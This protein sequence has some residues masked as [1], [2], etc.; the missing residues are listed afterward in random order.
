MIY[1]VCVFVFVYENHRHSISLIA[2]SFEWR[3]L[4]KAVYFKHVRIIIEHCKRSVKHTTLKKYN[5]FKEMRMKNIRLGFFLLR[6]FCF[7]QHEPHWLLS[8]TA[9]L[10]TLVLECSWFES[11]LTRLRNTVFLAVCPCKWDLMSINWLQPASVKT[12]PIRLITFHLI[13]WCIRYVNQ[14]GVCSNARINHHWKIRAR[15][16]RT[17]I[18]KYSFVNRSVT[19]WNQL[20][21]GAIELPTLKLIFS[22]RGLGKCKMVEEVKTIKSKK[23]REVKWREASY[24][25]E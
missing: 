7:Q 21:E 12:S 11:G 18:G 5:D 16:Q 6:L 1:K 17:D 24:R 8:L 9:T 23:W 2:C 14:T 25:G 19:D 13:P 3:I 15:K 20:P 10:S 4:H 22:K